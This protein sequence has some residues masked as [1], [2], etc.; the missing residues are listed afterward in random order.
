MHTPIK[1][2]IQGDRAS[3][4]EIAA[5]QYYDVPVALV[6]CQSFEEVFS[7]VLNSIVDRAFVAVSN[8]SHGPIEHVHA[9]MS[10]C[11]LTVEGEYLLP[12][13]QH[14]IGTVESDLTDV[15]SV[16]SHPIALSQCSAF[17]ENQLS[18]A[19]V[20]SYYD[21]SAAIRYVKQQND[22]SIVAIGSEEAATLYGLKIL[23]RSIQN[24]PKN[25][26]LFWSL[27]QPGSQS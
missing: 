9:L 6:Y 4:H 26:T 11:D 23:Q 18:E 3:F 21:T 24:D 13:H 19:S 2:A 12:I 1:V 7:L 8:S 15:K 14:L 16:L 17:I 22:R 20:Q 27:F 25:A 10:D 5:Y